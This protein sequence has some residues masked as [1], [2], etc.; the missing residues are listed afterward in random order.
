MRMT[1]AT[2]VAC[3]LGVGISTAHDAQAGIKQNTTI[4][5]Q[6][7]GSA[8]KQLA[9]QRDI[10]LVYRSELVG[11]RQTSGAVGEFTFDEAL[12]KLLKDTGLTYQ[13]IDDQAITVV[14]LSSSSSAQTSTQY[15]TSGVWERFRL[16]QAE[17][18]SST[19]SGS[20]RVSAGDTIA[21]EEVI[22]TARR[23]R[24]SL[25]DVPLSIVARSGQE[26]AAAQVDSV[27]ELARLVPGFSVS[28]NRSQPFANY[29][30][31]GI[32]SSGGDD[33]SVGVAVDGA[34]MPY[35]AAFGEDFNDIARVEVLRGPQGTL[36]GKNSSAGLLNYTT[37]DPTERFSASTGLGYGS[38]NEVKFNGA[39]SGPIAG[40]SLLGRLSYYANQRDGYLN[41]VAS[42]RM[43]ADDS[44][45]SLRGTLLYRPTD[46]ARV[47][48]SGYNV[49]RGRGADL[50]NR[51]TPAVSLGPLS[52]AADVQLQSD[53]ADPENTSVNLVG[54][55][56][57]YCPQHYWG[58]TLQ[59]DQ[60][61]GDY[62]LTSITAYLD[63]EW[64]Q[65]FT[66][67]SPGINSMVQA[68]Q[69]WTQELRLASPIGGR[70]D[71]QGGL[72]FYDEDHS[73][74]LD[75]KGPGYFGDYSAPTK[76]THYAAFGEANFHLSER[77]TLIGG[78]RWTHEKKAIVMTSLPAPEGDYQVF[79]VNEGT[80]D[81]VTV[82]NWS[83]RTGIQW[84]PAEPTMLYAT[85]SRGFKGP[86]FNPANFNE[87][88]SQQVDPEIA[89]TYEVGTKTI[90]LEGRLA[91][92]LAIFHTTFD[93]LQQTAVGFATAPD[94]S[95]ILDSNGNRISNYFLV[96]A[97][98]L[99]SQ[100]VELE[101]RAVPFVGFNL[102]LAGTYIDANYQDFTN[103][104]CYLG[105]AQFGT[106]CTADATG[107]G[108]QDLSDTRLPTPKYSATVGA[109]QEW[110]FAKLPLKGFVRADYQ[111]RS[112]TPLTSNDPFSG[113]PSVG[114]L[115]LSLGL[116]SRDD[117]FG[118][119]VYA[120]NLTNEFYELGKSGG[121][122]TVS[123]LLPLDYQRTFGVNVNYKVG[124]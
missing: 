62:T 1:V 90:W 104:P 107:L 86:A 97:G 56:R 19:S 6:G 13:Y 74:D 88:T 57:W 45:Q 14:P 70:V 105:Q 93:D 80:P 99:R 60:E 24:E 78:A 100:G 68:D 53:I 36:F 7:L 95:F 23:R 4:P 118:I 71:Y 82:E 94:G 12:T 10:Q 84:K 11:E 20:L 35:V 92:D 63:Y 21:L 101:V 113:L 98:K 102:S 9:G 48:L 25:Q 54:L 40:D 59:W 28:G 64:T 120:K 8:L 31:R 27:D 83:W 76:T 69:L 73:F 115:N 41:D 75:V 44:T 77:V 5:A 109:S 2:A 3:L 17:Q 61:L 96:N 103:A 67:P 43:V 72:Y 66:F 108:A 47:R 22:V 116:R 46:T 112:E 91:A 106:G 79:A 37:K 52:T 29:S 110:S 26:V 89:T 39:V 124:Q 30:L 122:G 58:S 34:V 18:G 117:N 38:Y 49:W 85:A 119:S 50:P 114:L 15:T 16:A 65:D 121:F 51:L 32:G 123:H 42:S 55:N 81:S 87:G 111:W 33:A